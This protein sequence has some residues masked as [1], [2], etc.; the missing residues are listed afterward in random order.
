MNF[1]N[2]VQDKAENHQLHYLKNKNLFTYVR[3]RYKHKLI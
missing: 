1:S 2:Q 3:I